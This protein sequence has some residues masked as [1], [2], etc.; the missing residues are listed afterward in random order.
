MPI[1]RTYFWGVHAVLL[2]YVLAALSVVVFLFGVY[3]R[4]SVWLSAPRGRPRRLGFSPRGAAMVA[5]DGLL[6]RR[7]F[8][9]DL[10]AGLTFSSMTA[11]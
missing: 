2:F 11:Y 9:G 7:I 10:V 1:E 6:G 3:R 5:A 8:R 4:V